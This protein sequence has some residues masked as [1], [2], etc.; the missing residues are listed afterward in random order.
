MTVIAIGFAMPRI[1]AEKAPVKRIELSEPETRAAIAAGS[2]ETLRSISAKPLQPAVKAPRVQNI[3]VDAVPSIFR[4]A[5][6]EGDAA[7]AKFSALPMPTPLASFDGLSNFDNINSYG[8]VILPPDMNGDVGPDHYVQA[9]NSL[10]RVYNKN[11][12]PATAPVKFSDIFAPLN[13]ACSA[14]NDGLPIVQYDQLADR[15]LISQYCNNFPPFRQLVAVSKTGDPTGAY[16]LWEF[17]MPN[18]RTPDFGKF[19]VWPDGYYMST[20]EF[21]GGDYAGVGMYAFDRNKMLSGDPSASYVYFSIPAA[22]I[23]RKRNMLP[24]D[25]DGLR[26]PSPGAPNIFVSYTANEYGDASDALRLFNFHVNF[27]TP[28]LSTFTER[29]D[30]PLAVAAFD[31]TSPDGR[32]DIAQPAPGDFLDSNSDRLNYRAAYRNLGTSESIVVNQT[33]RVAPSGPY[34]AGVRV[35][36]LRSTSGTYSIRENSTIGDNSSSRWIGGVAQDNQGNIAASYN[37]VNDAKQP[38]IRYSGRLA[39]ETPGSFRSESSIVEGTGVQ[40]AFGWRWGDYSSINVDPLDDCTFWVTGEYYSLASQDFSEFTWLTRIGSFKF[41]ECVAAPRSTV[42]GVITNLMTGQPIAGAIVKAGQYSHSS[43]GSGNYGTMA[44]LPGSYSLTASAAGYRSHTEDLDILNGQ[45]VTQDFALTP[46][47]IISGAGISLASESCSP[48]GAPDPGENVTISLSLKNTGSLPTQNLTA[49]LVNGGGVTNAGPPQIYGILPTN[50][51]PTARTFTF[52]V[53]PSL[54]CGA[55]INMSFVLQDGADNK[56]TLVVPLQSGRPKVA[57]EE[58]F[59]RSL[60]AQLP[61][62]WTRSIDGGSLN[63]D[64]SLNRSTSG[65]KSLFTPDPNQM[66]MNQVVTPTFFISTPNG[67]LSFQHFYDLETTFLEN[68]RYDGSVLEIS[69]D[70]GPWQDILAA[71]GSFVTGGYDGPLDTCCSNPLGGRPGWSGKS[72]INSLAEFVP[73]K[74]TLPAAAAGRKV[75]LRFRLGTDIGNSRAVEGE[76][77]DD[78]LVTDGYVCSCGT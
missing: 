40:R 42:T 26:T 71:G 41:D 78:F 74:A 53:D 48:N 8:L 21:N 38:S 75:Q 62:R 50:G 59:D 23:D 35:Y 36:E 33:V 29:A 76:F 5:I 24:S 31:P 6:T 72:G 64:I 14:R 52:T 19:G 7:I 43:N 2:S 20:E 16:F 4:S 66:G 57:F 10:V 1:Q 49:T 65:T 18:V 60:L 44:V 22:T 63:W 37:F 69:I 27:A 3:G 46:I 28:A 11:G 54:T 17:V 68:R 56:G 39:T 58:R 34:R 73:V 47:P 70:G 15:W 32:A 13:T 67:Q 51:Q 61:Q 9:T 55:V 12:T 77:I 30:S 45:S 25:L